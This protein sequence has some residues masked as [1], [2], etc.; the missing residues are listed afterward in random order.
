MT[1]DLLCYKYPSSFIPVVGI[2]V[3]RKTKTSRHRIGA[4]FW[5]VVQKQTAQ[6]LDLQK[7]VIII[8]ALKRMNAYNR[9][10]ILIG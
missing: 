1:L 6:I 5:P 3:R 9:I 8:N 10:L 7:K 2:S 4:E